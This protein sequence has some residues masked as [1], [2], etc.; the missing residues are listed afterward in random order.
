MKN[1]LPI[2]ILLIFTSCNSSRKEG[3]S[4]YWLEN[5]EKPEKQEQE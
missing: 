3:E 5:R 1:L 2:L 4:E